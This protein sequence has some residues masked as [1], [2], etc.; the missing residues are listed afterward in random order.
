[1]MQIFNILIL[2]FAFYYV[3]YFGLMSVAIFS[4][5]QI[6]ADKYMPSDRT[7]NRLSFWE[8]VLHIIGCFT[9]NWLFFVLLIIA[10]MTFKLLEAKFAPLIFMIIAMLGTLITYSFL[11]YKLFF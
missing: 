11:I 7:G 10:R 2:A 6:D 3:Y 4:E 5:A 8:L 1:M 9:I